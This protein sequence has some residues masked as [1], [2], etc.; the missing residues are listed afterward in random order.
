MFTRKKRLW[1]PWN[2]SIARK[3]RRRPAQER[4]RDDEARGA[5]TRGPGRCL[6]FRCV[7]CI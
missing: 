6:A 5:V 1:L 7:G 2:E 4:E 3:R